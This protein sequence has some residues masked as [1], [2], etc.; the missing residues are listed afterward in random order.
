MTL[1][2]LRPGK[3]RRRF[4]C[5]FLG[6]TVAS[7]GGIVPRTPRQL[8]TV[9]DLTVAVSRLPAAFRAIL[10]AMSQPM[11]WVIWNRA[12]FAAVAAG[13]GEGASPGARPVPGPSASRATIRAIT[14]PIASTTCWAAQLAVGPGLLERRTAHARPE[15][16]LT[17]YALAIS[18]SA[19]LS[20]VIV[21]GLC[22]CPL[23]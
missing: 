10:R 18:E 11:P 4:P 17:G 9:V 8:R 15:G 2:A 3:F 7:A 12:P 20:S 5:S 14:G 21:L 13:R 23:P 16:A 22:L 19:A 6:V 1:P